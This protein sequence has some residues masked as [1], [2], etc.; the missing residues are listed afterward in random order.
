M[1]VNNIYFHVIIY[2]K[3][4]NIILIYLFIATSIK[5]YINNKLIIK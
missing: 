1:E 2:L 3:Y 4:V 5:L